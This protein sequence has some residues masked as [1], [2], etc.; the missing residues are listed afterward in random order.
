VTSAESVVAGVDLGGTGS[1]FVVSSGGAVRRQTTAPSRELGA[2]STEERVS[3]LAAILRGLVPTGCR[4][5]G[6]GIGASG[7]V[8]LPLG[9][10]RNPNTLP[11]FSGFDLAGSLRTELGVEVLVDNDAVTAAIGEY[12]CGAARDCN[13]PLVVTLGTGIGVALLE[14]GRPFRDASG[15]HPECGHLPVFPSGPRCYCGLIGCWEMS[16]SRRSLE[17]R[18]EGVVGARDLQALEG[19]LAHD[20]PE[21]VTAAIDD[22]G[23][24]VGRGLEALVI[25]YGPDRVVLGGSASRFLPY[26]S[27]GLRAELERT[28][29]FRRDLDVVESSLGDLAGA[30]GASV[31]VELR[32]S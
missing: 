28:S 22:Y 19:L 23:H 3:N 2:G 7:P 26:F 25:A 13:R 20:A 18:V 27:H 21:A 11:W 31:M 17:A 10:I 4:L 6:V 30:I 32:G 24:A 9:V 29:D 12:K 16:A 15:Q 1:R 5:A 8:E 14:N